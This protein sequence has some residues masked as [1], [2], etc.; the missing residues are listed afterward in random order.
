MHR[1]IIDP[2]FARMKTARSAGL[3]YGECCRPGKL[4]DKT[5]RI[6]EPSADTRNTLGLSPGLPRPSG[7]C[8][9]SREVM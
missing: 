7:G 5:E 8:A 1:M 3:A 9:G 2:A 4:G 6:R